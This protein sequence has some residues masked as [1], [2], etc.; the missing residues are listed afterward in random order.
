MVSTDIIKLKIIEGVLRVAYKGLD[1]AINSILN[2]VFI[3]IFHKKN[4]KAKPHI[5]PL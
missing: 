2:K 4:I 1:T 3:I 5:V